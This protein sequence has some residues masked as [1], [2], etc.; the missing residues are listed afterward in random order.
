MT[1]REAV[2][3]LVDTLPEQELHAA[4]RFLEFLQ[5][6]EDALLVESCEPEEATPEELAAIQRSREDYKHGRFFSL[7]EVERRLLGP[8]PGRTSST[9]SVRQKR[10]NPKKASARR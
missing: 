10:G 1:P 3:K 6:H 9:V 4:Q 2:H 8:K 7:D 5:E